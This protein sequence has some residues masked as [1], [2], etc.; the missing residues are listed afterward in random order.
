MPELTHCP[1]CGARLA[2]GLLGETC[3]NCALEAAFEFRGPNANVP[4]PITQ[5]GPYRLME[6][7]GEGGL[8]VV[9]MAEQQEPIRRRVAVKLIKPGMD[10]REVIARFEAERQALALMDH[11]NIARIFEAGT[12][13][14]GHP[15]FAMELVRGVRITEYCDRHNLSTRERLD[16]FIIVAH[17]VQ[18]AHQKG[19]IHRDL[20]PS[21]ILVTVNDGVPVA[22]IIDF[23]IA[24]ATEHPLTD[25]TL[26]TRFNQLLGTPAYMSPEQAELTSLDIDTRTDIYSLGVLLYELLTGHT[27]FDAKEL[28]KV[29]LEHM[30]RTIR[31][32]EPPR[33]SARLSTLTAAEL[34]TV[35]R[36][37]HTES[38]KLIHSV[39]GDLDWIVMKCLE[40]NRARRYDS[41]TGLALDLR[42]HLDQK[43]V[44]ARPPSFAYIT[45]KFC[46][47]NQEK[48]ISAAAIVFMLALGVVIGEWQPLDTA[49]AEWPALA[50]ALL[51]TAFAVAITTVFGIRTRV[52]RRQRLA[53]R[54]QNAIDK[55]L[56]IAWTGD[57]DG[58]E[59]AIREAELTG[60]SIA[61]LRV[62][63][64]ALAIHGCR[65][66]EA[67]EH[68]EEAWKLSP[69]SVAVASM[70]IRAYTSL[71]Q[72]EQAQP[73]FEIMDHLTPTTPED[74]LLRGSLE[75]LVDPAGALATLNE[76][77]RRRP[78]GIARL[79]RASVRASHALDT[80][81][82]ADAEA[83]MAD[84]NSVRA[85]LA[86]NAQTIVWSLKAHLI[87]TQLY[88]EN[89]LSE[90][91]AAAWRQVELDAA[92]LQ[93]F[94]GNQ[95][96]MIGRAL[97]LMRV[98]GDP[99]PLRS[100][101]ASTSNGLNGVVDSYLA[102]ALYRRGEFQAA[103]DV[104]PARPG[105][106]QIPRDYARGYVL[107]E[108]PNGPQ[109]A[110]EEVHRLWRSN[111]PLWDALGIQS[112]LRLIGRKQ[113]AIDLCRQV[114]A[115][116]PSYLP[117][118]K[119]W[120]RRLLD[121]NC[122]D[123]PE[124]ELMKAAGASRYNQSE[125]HF[126]LG[127]T[128]LADGH[129]NEAW[130]HFHAVL[131]TRVFMF[132]DNDWSAAFLLRLEGDPNWPSWI[133]RNTNPAGINGQ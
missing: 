127:L 123:L 70:L 122:A 10:S 76:A 71:G 128:K 22:K 89:Q 86:N 77:V 35:A 34:T 80:G 52:A 74:F 56:L 36:Q 101:R 31:E 87:A 90:K 8:G 102:V 104:L 65:Y 126:Y 92:E 5:I 83:A 109:R 32:T 67:V 100:L 66:V 72:W 61:D 53:E 23:G 68:L 43:P 130:N 96:A 117:W 118:R 69:R 113:E 133:P 81:G 93:Q 38:P 25:R 78:T 51:I 42:R 41:V 48:L 124:D 62:L 60:A 108:L 12:T 106:V 40:K 21:N 15:Y 16:L 28:L 115:R 45:Q 6:K 18:H 125:A 29:G 1:K 9:Y 94:P 59:Q 14:N 85:L 11:P 99:A 50:A 114:R 111:L 19:I 24:K 27:P 33:P 49:P 75:A 120:Y 63:R 98:G 132:W 4:E 84:I 116:R 44:T 103:L 57:L 91:R 7:I 26:F 17:A 88:E 95:A 54:R 55:A 64:G 112:I 47:R 82:I 121:Y 20:K 46:R 13:D 129:R 105:P 79:H 110:W 73:L 97:Y 30:L 107:T 119:E 131:A 37:R 58:T 39:S 3:P 2:P